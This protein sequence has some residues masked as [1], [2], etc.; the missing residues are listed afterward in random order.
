MYEEHIPEGVQ[1]RSI[2]R[3]AAEALLPRLGRR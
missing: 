3:A 1:R 2:D